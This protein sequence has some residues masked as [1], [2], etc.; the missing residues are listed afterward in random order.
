M[1]K[2]LRSFCAILA[3]VMLTAAL[4]AIG[5]TTTLPEDVLEEVLQALG[6]GPYR[7]TLEALRTGEIVEKGSRGDT[8]KGVQQTL[9]AFGQDISADGK[10]GSKTLKALN[11]VQRA[12]GLAETEALDATGYEAL[13][14]RLLICVDEEAAEVL[15]SDAMGEEYAY[16][17]ACAFEAQGHYYLAKER[18]EESGYGDWE[19]RAEAC[20][21]PWP[22]NGQIYKNSSVKGSG[23]KLIVKV[24]AR[25]E[26]LAVLVKVY[27]EDGVLARMMFIG[28]SGKA[29]TSL[30]AGTYIVKDGT[31]RQWYGEKDS[32]GEDAYY[33]V[34]T[35]DASGSQELK[36]RKN[37]ETT[38]TMNVQESDSKGD[39]VGSE[40]ELWGDF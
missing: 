12:F 36:L 40:F 16:V 10:A 26:E 5:E 4:P 13:L 29:S 21:Q 30:P 11:D 7:E 32:F 28:G 25:D 3:L 39:S 23:S 1:N 8:A 34:M 38:I 27:T 19:A 6:E 15:L 14:P 22:K 33:E 18:F 20:V 35:F 24:N 2:L 31:G 37:Y 9:I 17:S